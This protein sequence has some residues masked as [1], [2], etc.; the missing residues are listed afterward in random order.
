M[1]D[2]YQPNKFESY[3]HFVYGV[4]RQ[5]EPENVLEIGLGHGTTAFQIIKALGEIG[6]CKYYVIELTP[7]LNL[8]EHFTPEQYQ[9]IQGDSHNP[10]TYVGLP[11]FDI[12]CIDGDHSEGGVYRDIYT[13]FPYLAENGLFIFHDTNSPD[14]RRGIVNGA[15]QGNLEYFF[16]PEFYVG[17]ARKKRFDYDA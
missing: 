2:P 7:H 3:R 4:V 9:V 5:T 1:N 14:V 8:I 13:S 15:F 12:I 16:F 6:K 10:E 17:V 11:L